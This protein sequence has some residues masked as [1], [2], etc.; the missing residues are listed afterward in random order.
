MRGSPA[1][2]SE[3]R[4]LACV[5]QRVAGGDDPPQLIQRQAAQR[6]LGHQRMAGMRRVERTAEQTDRHA[7]LGMRHAQ[8]TD[9]NVRKGSRRYGQLGARN[10]GSSRGAAP[11]LP[12]TVAMLTAA[13]ARNLGPDI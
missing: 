3:R 9:G 12:Q 10:L 4:E 7:F 11:M 1:I 13:S 6:D 5:L 8:V 2:R